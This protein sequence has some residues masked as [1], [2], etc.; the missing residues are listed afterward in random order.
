MSRKIVLPV[1]FC[2][3]IALDQITKFVV[4]AKLQLYDSVEVIPGL[5]NITY[6]LNPGAAFGILR[7]QSE[8][9]RVAFFTGMTILA[10][11]L[12]LTLII[13]EYRFKVRTFAYT[14]V[15][16][17]A[18]GNMIDRLRVG[19]VVDFLDF[20]FKNWHWYTFNVADCLITVSIGALLIDILFLNKGVKNG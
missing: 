3:F 18:L 1:L 5:F 14:A 9:F 7:E 4:Q 15:L 6:V 16:A 17:G 13:R 11:I 20:Y 2:V 10:C 19:K 12:I 8:I